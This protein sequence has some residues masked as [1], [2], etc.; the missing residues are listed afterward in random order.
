MNIITD[1]KLPISLVFSLIFIV[2]CASSNK[3][4]R[5]T[6]AD[7]IIKY[8]TSSA[9]PARYENLYPGKKDYP[10][11]CQA[12][13]YP[14]S[15]A[16]ACATPAESCRFVGRQLAIEPTTGFT[17]RWL[18]HA[19]FYLQSADGSR[20]LL[21]PVSQQ[22]DWPVD[23]AFTL[24]GGFF[25]PEP[26]W[27]SANE[28]AEVDAVLYSHIHYDHFNKADIKKIGNQ[29]QYFVPLGFAQHFANDGYDITEMAWFANTK[30]AELTLSF[31]PSHHFSSRV[32]VP[33][34]YEDN[35]ATLWGGWVIEQQGKRVFFAGDTGY[36]KHFK[37]IQQ[38]YGDMDICLMPIASY[39]HKENSNWY[40]YVHTTPEDALVAAQELN[41]KVM[42][43]WGYGNNSWQMGD[44]SSH[45]ALLRLLKMHK[46]MQSQVPLYIL[47]EG[48]AVR[49]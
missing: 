16:L 23:W 28:L 26:P 20:L 15:P 43:P 44:H 42:I 24:A 11:T 3:V 33:Y 13:C 14:P 46:T 36:S 41:C 31:V 40:R 45:S 22:F 21:D 10:L 12:P 49:L 47:N 48:E 17:L 38:R 1:T 32:L 30:L 6:P 19:S 27:L 25:R 9:Q 8:K 18:G 34:I 4:T 29:A 39:Y 37:D 5:L 7:A 2:G 35:D